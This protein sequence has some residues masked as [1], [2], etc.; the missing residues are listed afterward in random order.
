[1]AVLHWPSTP[2]WWL[3]RADLIAVG[4]GGVLLLA[5][6]W[7]LDAVNSKLRLA[8]CIGLGFFVLQTA[9]LDALVWPAYFEL[10]AAG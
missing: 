2:L 5:D 8:V 1:M 3:I 4:T 9:V 7:R 6:V 10:P